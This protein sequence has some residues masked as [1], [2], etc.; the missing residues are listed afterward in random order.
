MTKKKTHKG[1]MNFFK[2]AG[3]KLQS[4]MSDHSQNFQLF[5]SLC[6]RVMFLEN[7]AL[8]A[9]FGAFW[10][11]SHKIV[12]YSNTLLFEDFLNFVMM[13]GY[14]SPKSWV[15][16]VVLVVLGFNATL[17]AKVISWRSVTHMCFLAFS[18]QY[19]TTFLSKATDYFF[20]VLLQR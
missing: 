7:Y 6:I 4:M 2:L 11:T 19:Y 8:R 13:A 10:H 9:V 5:M 18:H 15:W 12:I 17:T 14:Y 16:L 3:V 20:H 1:P